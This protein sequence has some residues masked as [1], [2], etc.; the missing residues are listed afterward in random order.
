M[1][2]P[3]NTKRGRPREDLNEE[4]KKWLEAFLSRSEVSYTNPGRKGHVYVGKSDGR[5]RYKQRLYLLWN[6]GDLLTEKV[7]DTDTFYQ[8]FQKLL[9]FSQ[10]Y[11]F[12]KYHKE[13]CRIQNIPHVSYLCEICENCVLLAKVLN[14]RLVCPLPANSHELIER[15][16]CNLQEV[17]CV[18]D[19]CPTCCVAE[20]VLQIQPSDSSDSTDENESKPAIYFAWEKVDKRVTK[21]E[22]MVSFDDEFAPLRVKSKF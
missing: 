12:L 2:I 13:Y 7:D 10:L 8:N 4:E 22:Q 1:K 21:A 3:F 17:D 14:T 18:M 6:L 19:S 20:I 16:S 11:H 15:F 5:R 9:T